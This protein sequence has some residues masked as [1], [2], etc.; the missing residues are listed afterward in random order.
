MIEINLK[1]CKFFLLF[2]TQRRGEH[3]W[4]F[5]RQAPEVFEG[6]WTLIRDESDSLQLHELYHYDNGVT[7]I[8]GV[9]WGEK[10]PVHCT[11][12]LLYQ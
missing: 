2:L 10:I 7:G 1:I 9:D 11:C 6:P 3:G 4:A 5:R 12:V 8:G